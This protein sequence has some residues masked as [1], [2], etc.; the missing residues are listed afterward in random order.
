MNF[1][2]FDKNLKIKITC[3]AS[4]LGLWAML[5]QLHATVWYP[6][7]FASWSITGAENKT[8]A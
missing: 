8:L 5:E 6:T 7:A 4:K 3:D 2:S 1:A